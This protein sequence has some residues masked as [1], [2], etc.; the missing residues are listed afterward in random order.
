M[1]SAWRGIKILYRSDPSGDLQMT[2]RCSGLSVFKAFN[3]YPP[4]KSFKTSE[5]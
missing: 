3:R 1:K 4:F 2:P 5:D